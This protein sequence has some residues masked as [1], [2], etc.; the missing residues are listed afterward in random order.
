MR[1]DL[2]SLELPTESRK[3]LQIL[4]ESLGKFI[5]AYRTVGPTTYCFIHFMK[6]QRAQV[7]GPNKWVD[8]E[9]R[10]SKE[11]AISMFNFKEGP[12]RKMLKVQYFKH[13]KIAHH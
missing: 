4:L 1:D 3:S 9:K 12:K 13:P 7:M 10:V 2:A 6:M 8:V 5:G 11:Y